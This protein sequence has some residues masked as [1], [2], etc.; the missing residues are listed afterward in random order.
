VSIEHVNAP[1]LAKPHG[2]SYAVVATGSRI[3]H[4]S[5]QVSV[6]AD[7]NL[8]GEGDLAV[9]AKQAM[10]NL[11]AALRGTGADVADVVKLNLYVVDFDAEREEAMYRG[12]GE[13]SRETG[14]RRTATT[15]I[16]VPVLGVP[17]ALIEIDGVAITE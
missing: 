11:V 9:Q 12:L 17:G 13:A 7:G 4:L 5:G 8:V 2:Y 16:S 14:M 1:E 15:L 6:D 3:V 10:L